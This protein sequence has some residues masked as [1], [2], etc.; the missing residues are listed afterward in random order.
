MRQVVRLGLFLTACCL[1]ALAALFLFTRL[2]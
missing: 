2:P 1:F